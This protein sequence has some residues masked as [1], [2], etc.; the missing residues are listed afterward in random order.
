M[1]EVVLLGGGGDDIDIETA[2]QLGGPFRHPGIS[3]SPHP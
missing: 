3:I 1:A 2:V